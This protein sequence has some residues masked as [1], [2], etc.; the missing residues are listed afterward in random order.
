MTD[1]AE[2]LRRYADDRSEEAFTELVGR[3][4]SLVYHAAFR[5]TAQAQLAEEASQQVFVALARNAAALS[6]H[7]ALVGWLY[8]TT[9][10][11]V[12]EQRRQ[13]REHE[14]YVM[15]NTFYP[16][17]ADWNQIRPVLDEVLERLSSRERSAVLLRHFEGRSFAEVGAALRL[18]EEAARKRVVRG[19]EKLR[20]LLARR[21]I[22]STSA[23]LAVML[24][25]Q[26]DLAAPAGL[27]STVAGA[28]LAG[29]GIA[30]STTT[31]GLIGFM[32][33]TKTT[34][35]AIAIAL[36]AAI[37]AFYEVG[38]AN[39]E[40]SALFEA[41]KQF[42]SDQL[43]LHAAEQNATTAA[44][45]VAARNAKVN[46]IGNG[47]R[48]SNSSLPRDERADGQAFLAAFGQ[49]K[50]L[51]RVISKYQLERAYAG[52]YKQIGLTPGQID[53]FESQTV[54]HWL[55]T[56]EVFPGGMHPGEAELPDDQLRSIF[57]D[58][59]LQAY[60]D[61]DRAQNAYGWASSLAQAAA[62][63]G[64]PLSSDQISGLAQA[65]INNSPDYASGNSIDPVNVDWASALPQAKQLLNETQWEQA[66]SAVLLSQV[67]FRSMAIQKNSGKTP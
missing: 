6:R 33:I 44:N 26:A 31:L 23:A 65:V 53:E 4:L 2:L 22:T 40:K 7:T 8:T 12:A 29:G 24:S 5:R 42:Q 38:R 55:D 54:Q 13:R 30:G 15:Q 47:S 63:G 37:I 51:L 41:T 49:A 32:S 57:G 25:S 39:L 1:D 11:A 36:A 67:M 34:I 64:T 27:A 18:T 62:E 16:P 59:G 10:F 17:V 58:S 46:A 45:K 60:K 35:A 43:H 56:L 61:F 52:F 48:S 9:R 3:H 20:S 14:A 21:G 19:V 50:S 66:Q 28:A